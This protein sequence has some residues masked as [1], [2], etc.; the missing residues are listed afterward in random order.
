MKQIF[1][2]E[3]N[4]LEV[5]LNEVITATELPLGYS[6]MVAVEAHRNHWLY[7]FN[8]ETLLTDVYLLSQGQDNLTSVLKGYDGLKMRSWTLLRH[9][10]LGDKPYLMTYEPEIGDMA[11]YEIKEDGTL[12]D[13]YV[14]M[15]KRSWPTQGFTEVTPIVITGLV[16][17]LGYDTHKGTVAIFSLDVI[18]RSP[19][20]GV[21]P[22]NMLNVWYH[23]WAARWENFAFFTLGQSNFFFKINKGKLNVNID[24]ILDDPSQGS[25]EIGSYLQH[26]MPNALQVVLSASIPWENGEPYLA[27]L[28]GTTNELD[29]YRIHADCQ[30]WSL[31]GKKETSTASIMISYRI[32]KKSYLLLY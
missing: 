29:I 32:D 15:N 1:S 14:F 18:S 9:F 3:P 16:Y 30:G 24:H 25:V 22:L 6:A 2:I 23:Q 11:F 26:K 21:P 17:V 7:A 12:T 10:V 27:T 8:N 20:K 31:L 13:P 5:T 28:D 19:Q 4:G